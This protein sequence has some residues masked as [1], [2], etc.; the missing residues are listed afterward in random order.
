MAFTYWRAS[1]PN[2]E[3]G[4]GLPVRLGVGGSHAHTDGGLLL[5]R[6]H[7][8]SIQCPQVDGGIVAPQREVGLGGEVSAEGGGHVGGCLVTSPTA[9]SGS[10]RPMSPS[11]GNG[12]DHRILEASSEASDARMA[13]AEGA[14]MPF[15]TFV[16]ESM[17]SC[18]HDK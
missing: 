8:P 18:N 17:Q 7:S 12:I 13:V 1:G 9:S 4:S 5:W 16:Q 11:G 14:G 2:C 10:T 6:A 3:N 15:V